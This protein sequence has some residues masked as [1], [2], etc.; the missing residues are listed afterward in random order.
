MNLYN[1]VKHLT[2]DTEWKSDIKHKKT[3]HTRKPRATPPPPLRKLKE[4]F[5][6]SS[7]IIQEQDSRTGHELLLKC[8]RTAQEHFMNIKLDY[9]KE[10]LYL[11]TALEKFKNV[12]FLKEYFVLEKFKNIMFFSS[13]RTYLF[14]SHTARFHGN[15]KLLN[16]NLE[17]HQK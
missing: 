2:Q 8:S 12:L 1:Q 6:K 3:S 16:Q 7:F 4:Q 11:T 13:S 15:T 10:Q 14:Y 5:K 17:K 9:F